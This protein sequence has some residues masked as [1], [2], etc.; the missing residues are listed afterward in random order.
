MD[1]LKTC[2][3]LEYKKI[4]SKTQVELIL[5]ENHQASL[6]KNSAQLL[7]TKTTIFYFFLN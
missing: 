6:N 1:Q 5:A 3:D 2:H 7:M 4:Q